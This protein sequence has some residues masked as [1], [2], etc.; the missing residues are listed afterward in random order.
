MILRTNKLMRKTAIKTLLVAFIAIF[1]TNNLSAQNLQLYYDMGHK[2]SDLL[3]ERPAAHATFEMMKPDKFGSTFL[4]ADADFNQEGAN[5]VFLEIV[6]SLRFWDLPLHIHLEYNGGLTSQYP[7]HNMGY[8]GLS[9][10]F[11]NADHSK[12][13]SLAASYKYIHGGL[14]QNT[15]Q[16]AAYWEVY[17]NNKP[18]NTMGFFKYW[19]EDRGYNKNIILWSN[20]F[21]MNLNRLECVNDDLRLS[22]GGKLEISQNQ[23]GEG[24]ACVPMVGAK[25]SF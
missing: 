12:N 4:L 11:S 20:Q 6:R 25:W 5:M 2:T 3:T 24:F 16:L 21:W 23:Y 19:Q 9:Y 1:T 13:L 15:F 14:M 17:T 22:V 7:I 8:L 18:F 10:L